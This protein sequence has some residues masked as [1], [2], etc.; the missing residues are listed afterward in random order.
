MDSAKRSLHILIPGLLGPVT[1]AGLSTAPIRVPLLER[2]LV[3]ARQARIPGWDLESTLCHLFGVTQQDEDL[4]VAAIR[5]FGAGADTDRRFWLQ[6]EPIYLRADHSRLLLFD[7]P[8]SELTIAELESLAV[9][10]RDHFHEKDWLVE[11]G[12]SLPWFVSPIRFPRI[13]TRH[14]GDVVGRNPDQFMPQGEDG[15]RWHAILNEIQMLFFSSTLHH[16]REAK[17]RIPVSGLWFSGGGVLPERLPAG[18]FDEIHS[19]DH[20]IRGLAK[21]SNT[22]VIAPA[23]DLYPM[24]KSGGTKLLVYTALQRLVWQNDVENWYNGLAGVNAWLAPIAEA[25]GS[26]M[27]NELVLYPCDGRL[28][29]LTRFGRWRFWKRP[30]PITSW[31]E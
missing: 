29:R 25:L 27:V 20:F 24:L 15:L 19:D 9:L 6:A 8:D 23:G 17:D 22:P 28:F 31:V 11:A 16:Q 12:G 18:R 7:V 2:C 5:R 21:L 26:G 10:F 13:K 4:P 1:G 14:L 3:H 30:R